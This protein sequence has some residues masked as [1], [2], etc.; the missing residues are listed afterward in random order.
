[1]A[2]QG[3]ET[4]TQRRELRLQGLAAVALLLA[5]SLVLLRLSCERGCGRVRLEGLAGPV[6]TA[7]VGKSAPICAPCSP[8]MSAM[9]ACSSR[10]MSS[11]RSRCWR[12]AAAAA[13][14]DS[15][16]CADKGQVM[17]REGDR[18]PRP[19]PVHVYPHLLVPGSQ[20]RLGHQRLRTCIL[21]RSSCRGGVCPRLGQRLLELRAPPCQ[22]RFGCCRGVPRT[23]RLRRTPGPPAA[24][25]TPSPAL[26]RLRLNDTCISHLIQSLAQRVCPCPGRRRLPL[27]LCRARLGCPARL[28][29]TRCLLLG[30]AQRSPVLGR[31]LSQFRQLRL[32]SILAR[33]GLGQGGPGLVPL[34]VGSSSWAALSAGKHDAYDGTDSLRGVRC[35]RPRCAGALSSPRTSA[36]MAPT[37]RA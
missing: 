35:G 24:L 5:R 23:Q 26:H 2:A 11:M 25:A 10:S 19:C 28:G 6:R 18:W 29:Q 16:T 37:T 17:C 7:P 1:M 27:P 20:L 30:L 36:R 15:R 13:S 14:R 9:R 21:R 34:R 33:A 22:A 12:S 32:G 8:S 4:F 31:A 3:L